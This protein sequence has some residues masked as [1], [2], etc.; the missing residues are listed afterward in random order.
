[1]RLVDIREGTVAISSD[2][3]PQILSGELTISAMQAE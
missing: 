2:L 3:N 1:M